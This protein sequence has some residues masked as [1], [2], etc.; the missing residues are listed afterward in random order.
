MESNSSAATSGNIIKVRVTLSSIGYG[1]LMNPML[2][3]TLDQLQGISSKKTVDKNRSKEEVAAEKL[4]KGP[5]GAIGIPLQYLTSCLAEAG[6]YV[7]SGKKQL[8]TAESTKIF[9]ILD[10]GKTTFLQFSAVDLDKVEP[11]TAAKMNADGWVADRKKGN[12]K[13]GAKSVAVAIIRPWFPAWAITFDVEI[14]TSPED[15]GADETTV[16]ALFK[17]AG[18]M[19]GIGDFRPAKK[20]QYGRFE[21]TGWEVLPAA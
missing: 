11:E 4:I 14:N 1:M 17:A 2:E 6:R 7:K 12:L 15:Y 5:G 3:D 10:F 19:V 21:V 9:S 16:K 20:G 18:S 13:N 8:S